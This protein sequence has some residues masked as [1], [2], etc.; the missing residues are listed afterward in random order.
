ME[1]GDSFYYYFLFPPGRKVIIWS[2]NLS[3]KPE[4]RTG[5]MNQNKLQCGYLLWHFPLSVGHIFFST[6]IFSFNYLFSSVYMI[7]EARVTEGLFFP[8]SHLSPHCL[9][10]L[11]SIQY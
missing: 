4:Q 11:L 1:V 7:V 6:G 5:L 8:F 3:S 2:K 9:C 10:S